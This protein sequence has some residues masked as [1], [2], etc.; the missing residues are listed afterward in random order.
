MARSR[1]ELV[2]CGTRDA[3]PPGGKR[4]APLPERQRERRPQKDIGRTSTLLDLFAPYEPDT[5]TATSYASNADHA[6]RGETQRPRPPAKP[7]RGRSKSQVSIAQ[8][9]N[10]AIDEDRPPVSPAQKDS[11]EGRLAITPPPKKSRNRPPPSQTKT[12]Q[13]PLIPL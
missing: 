12:H 8:T 3:S 9:D 13:L 1:C 5:K 11:A 4:R 6:R 10:D 2:A 7:M